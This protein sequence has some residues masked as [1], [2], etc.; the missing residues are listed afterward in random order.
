MKN[1]RASFI[2]LFSIL[3]ISCSTMKKK[4]DLIIY[5]ATVYTVDEQFSIST[6]LVIRDGKILAH[7]EKEDIFGTYEAE[8]MLD[9]GGMFVYPGFYDAHCHFL[10]YGLGKLKKADLVGTKSFDAVIEKVKEHAEKNG[11][12]WIEGR[13]WDQN[14]WEVKEF[15]NREELDIA[16]PDK[17]VILTRIDGHAALVNGE[18]LRR[19]GI[20]AETRVTGGE[21]HLRNGV[22][23]GILIDN[24][25]ELI[26][27]QIPDNSPALK[28]TALQKAQEDCFAVGLTSVM[29]AGMAVQDILLIDS[30]NK[31]GSMKIRINAMLTPMDSSY[32][33][34]MRKG[35]YKTDRLHVNSI[36][37]YADGALGSRGACMLEPYSDDDGNYGLVMYPEDYYREVIENALENDFQV[38]THAIG[39]SGNRFIIDLYAE[40]LKG[41]ND[42]RWRVEHAQILHPDDFNKFG[43]YSI[44]PS[45]QA[46]HCT[47]DMYWADERVGEERIKGA[48][49]WQQLLAQNG[50]L[51][52][53]TDFPIEHIS[54]LKTYYAAVSRKDL[55]GHP[56]EGFQFEEAL[57]REEALRS[58]TI[59]AAKGS[60]EEDEKGSL[61][62]GKLADIVI[63]DRDLMSI[64]ENEIP[65]AEVLY[66]IV[67]GEILYKGK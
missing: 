19:A 26:S 61:E 38:N 46:T 66:T 42:R 31:D 2:L 43:S 20:T 14:D 55:E 8:K 1:L 45:I 35:E 29:D 56:E 15:P 51:P 11:S 57:S 44:I 65:D 54:P 33:E 58:V 47:S 63:L 23:S 9:A 36:K 24:A 62:A 6:A 50:W 48:Y 41:P 3:L 12:E 64:P 60:F 39:D 7:G 67:N 53:G 21:I 10:S 22:P 5:N 30:L 40:Y 25:I 13:G 27:E 18:A 28:S 59:W 49:A 37:L 17:P 52:N 32:L 34:F 4:A 16:F